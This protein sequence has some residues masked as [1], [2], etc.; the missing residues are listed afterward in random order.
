MATDLELYGR[1]K[2]GSEFPVDVMLSPVETTEG[3]LILVV[4][5]D[6]T[7]RKRL[8]EAI[9]NKRALFEN[10]MSHLAR[11]DVLTG[12]PNRLLLNDRLDQA[13]SL[14]RRNHSQLA[15]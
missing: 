2:D 4:I 5:R 6:I 9:R 12:L 13:V 15:V 8:E 10:E 11:H 3:R 7:R 14:A 1:H